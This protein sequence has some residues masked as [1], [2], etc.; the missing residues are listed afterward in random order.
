MSYEET[1]N[2]LSSIFEAYFEVTLLFHTSTHLLI[3]SRLYCLL[4]FLPLK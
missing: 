3:S 1:L 4:I 2:E